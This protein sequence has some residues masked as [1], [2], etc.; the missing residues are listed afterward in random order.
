MQPQGSHALV[1]QC[2]G[3]TAVFNATLAAVI[4]TWQQAVG[5]GGARLFGARN[6]LQGLATGDWIALEGLAPAQLATL[7]QQPGAA[8]GCGRHRL[9]EADL[10]SVVALLRERAVGT[11]FLIGGNGTAAAAHMLAQAAPSLRVLALPKT[12]DND[13]PGT[14]VAP[15]YGSAARYTAQ[16][17]RDAWLDLHAMATFDDVVI[18]EVMGRHAGWLAAASVLARVDP[19]RPA[20]GPDLVLLPEAPLDEDD[21]LEAIARR[22]AGEGVC[23][24][25]AAEGVRDRE[26]DFLAEKGGG[27]GTDGSGQRVLSLATG[28]AAYLTA[29]VTARLGLRARQI[30]PNT[31]QRAGWALASELDRELAWM[32]GAVAVQQALDGCS[33]RLLALVRSGN[34]WSVEALP[35]AEIVGRER[36][37]PGEWVAEGYDV[38]PEFVA[39]AAPF[40][41]PLAP[42]PLVW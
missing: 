23:L 28:V 26:G 7:A 19:A 27:A 37:F 24:V 36:L 41:E 14:D 33:D 8:L 30:R 22:H 29:Q 34:L 32:V 39:Y 5:A 12:V 11:L 38:A 31:L 40:V 35:L 1:V 6:G 25:A 20:G 16:S 9:S 2:G 18:Y 4:Q 10:P 21:L 15:G 42:G 17:V 13:L 3:P